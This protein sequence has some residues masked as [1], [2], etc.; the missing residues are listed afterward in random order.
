M[1]TKKFKKWIFNLAV[2]GWAPCGDYAHLGDNG[3][4]N[5]QRKDA[6]RDG[7]L[8]IRGGVKKTDPRQ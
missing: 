7:G 2:R 1:D 4:K 3:V 6:M 8:Q 5:A